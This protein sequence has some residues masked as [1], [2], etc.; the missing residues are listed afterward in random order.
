MGLFD[1]IDLELPDAVDSVRPDAEQDRDAE[2]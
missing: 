1:D 2:C